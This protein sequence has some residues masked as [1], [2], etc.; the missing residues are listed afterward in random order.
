[1]TDDQDIKKQLARKKRIAMEIASTIHDIVEDRFMTDYNELTPLSE[2]A[3]K[4][5]ED[6]HNFKK[7]HGL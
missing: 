2:Q 3:I 5:V 7:T 4:A 1:M 6:Y